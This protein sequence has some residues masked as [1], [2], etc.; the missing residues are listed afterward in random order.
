MVIKMKTLIFKKFF[1]LNF[2]SIVE[3]LRNKEEVTVILFQDAIYLALK[4]TEYSTA[5]THVVEEGV[6]FYLLKKDVEKRGILLNLIPN[7]ELINYDQFIDLLFLEDQRVI[8][9]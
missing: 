2:L 9:L 4:N 1:D 5:I 6:K 7:V 8:N 3:T